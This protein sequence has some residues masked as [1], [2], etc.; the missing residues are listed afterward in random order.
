MNIP[1][2][3]IEK[4]ERELR[5]QSEDGKSEDGGQDLRYAADRLRELLNRYKEAK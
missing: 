1:R 5:I 3:E 4:L 2:H